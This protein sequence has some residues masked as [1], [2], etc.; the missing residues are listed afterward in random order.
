MLQNQV[1]VIVNPDEST[2]AIPQVAQVVPPIQ[3]LILNDHMPLSNT[4]RPS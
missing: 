3:L 4:P 2:R 1:L